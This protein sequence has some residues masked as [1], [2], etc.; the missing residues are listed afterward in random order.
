M[1]PHIIAHDPIPPYNLHPQLLTLSMPSLVSP[2]INT[3][4]PVGCTLALMLMTMVLTRTG[5]VPVPTPLG[6]LPGAR[7]CPMGQFKSLAPQ[8]MKAFKRAKDALVSLSAAPSAVGQPPPSLCGLPCSIWLRVD[9]YPPLSGLPC[10]F[11]QWAD[12]CSSAVKM[13]PPSFWKLTP[14]LM[15]LVSL[16]SHCRGLTSALQLCP[17]PCPCSPGRVAPAEE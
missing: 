5:A 10:T 15:S 8:D 16:Q 17:N 14:L 13:T 4:L 12:S 6:A 3:D 11:S 2:S 7:D 9:P 1:S